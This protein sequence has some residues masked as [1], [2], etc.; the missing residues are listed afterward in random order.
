MNIFLES[1]DRLSLLADAD[2]VIEYFANRSG[3]V[4]NAERLMEIITTWKIPLFVT[5][6]CRERLRCSIGK[7]G[8]EFLISTFDELFSKRIV[9]AEAHIIDRAR[10]SKLK[11]FEA[12]LEIA[13]ATELNIVAIVTASPE[14]SST[15]Y[16]SILTV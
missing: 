8:E 14:K 4:N 9:V 11:S 6:S 1:T 15:F 10:S 13:L 12:A 16:L 2:I 5:D 3:H 7:L